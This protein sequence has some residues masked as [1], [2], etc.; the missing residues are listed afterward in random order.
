MLLFTAGWLLALRGT[1]RT[2]GGQ[3]N[4]EGEWVQVGVPYYEVTSKGRES[5]VLKLELL[6]Q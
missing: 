5:C 3:A 2:T 6:K 1:D 4:W